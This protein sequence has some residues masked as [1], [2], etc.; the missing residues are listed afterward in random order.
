MIQNS[1]DEFYL[2]ENPYFTISSRFRN[3]MTIIMEEN[4]LRPSIFTTT[5]T[6]LFHFLNSRIKL[7]S[8]T[9]LLCIRINSCIMHYKHINFNQLCQRWPFL[10]EAAIVHIEPANFFQ[11]CRELLEPSQKMDLSISEKKTFNHVSQKLSFIRNLLNCHKLRLVVQIRLCLIMVCATLKC[12]QSS[13][14]D[15]RDDLSQVCCPWL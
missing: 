12:K 8:I 3:S 4:P 2:I 5:T 1:I 11:L 9:S 14:N 10:P 15:Y 7:K 6:K 13:C